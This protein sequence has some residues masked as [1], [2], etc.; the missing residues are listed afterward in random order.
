M[1]KKKIKRRVM[2]KGGSVQDPLS[3]Y[4]QQQYFK[5]ANLPNNIKTPDQSLAE[6]E[7]R[8]ANAQF[9]ADSNPLTQGLD[10]VGNMAMQYGMNMMGGGIKGGE[11]LFKSKS[12]EGLESMTSSGMDLQIPEYTAPKLN[13]SIPQIKAAYGAKIPNRTPVEVEGEEAA[14]LPNGQMIDFQGPSHEQGGIDV[15]LPGGTDVYSK[16]LK[17]PDGKSM[18]KRKLKRESDMRKLSKKAKGNSADRL[19][20]NSIERTEAN[21]N[22]MDAF[23]MM[24]QEQYKQQENNLP[25]EKFAFGGP[26][27]DE[28]QLK[29]AIVK[30]KYK[31]EPVP[32][33]TLQTLL[34][35]VTSNLP[36]APKEEQSK[37]G[38]LK[39]NIGGIPTGG[40]V[41]GI[42]GNLKQAF[43]P[44]KTTLANRGSDTPNVNQYKDFGK[45]SLKTIDSM[46][47]IIGQT[48]DAQIKELLDRAAGNVSKNRNTAR[49]VNT[50]R[51]LDIASN[52][53]T[54]DAISGINNNYASQMLG[55]LG[56]EAQMEAQRDTNVMKGEALADDANRQDKDAFYSQ[57]S[58][59][60]QA[61]GEAY[62]RTGKAF[63]DI[64][65]RDVNENFMNALSDYVDIDWRTGKAR[66][67]DGVDIT[68]D[69]TSTK[70]EEGK[71]EK[72]DKSVYDNFINP[73][74]GKVFTESQWKK[75]QEDVK[76]NPYLDAPKEANTSYK[77]FLDPNTKKPFS[78][79]TNYNKFLETG[80]KA[81]EY[82][83]ADLF[84]GNKKI[85]S[86]LSQK[87]KEHVKTELG[88]YL[89]NNN[90]SDFNLDDAASIKA[91]EKKLDLKETGIIGPKVLRA[92]RLEN[93]DIKFD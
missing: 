14:E 8:V 43:D 5:R 13:L 67:K 51:A 10:L 54:L 80:K 71:S 32:F 6:N 47:G 61:I 21:N 58:R 1:A 72:I 88:I 24:L 36:Q 7:I 87:D 39:D 49:G 38:M 40:D 93:V 84:K 4:L 76:D 27:D 86:K 57:L 78:S 41:L 62:T 55:I 82:V 75:Y 42:Y 12:V 20:K 33:E 34:N 35:G 52:N 89:R 18:A 2:A 59:D 77:N 31:P 92:L 48:K 44:Y 37:W 65:E 29:E 53:A 17:G 60:Q 63:N 30:P 74:T 56:Q 22:Q 9:K 73:G 83:G 28:I 81:E 19:L 25:I 68:K 50:L 15:N 91:L 45:D 70:T 26:V 23:D 69:K 79:I 11:G 64:K 16:R 90:M 85:S 46:K 66:M 3:D